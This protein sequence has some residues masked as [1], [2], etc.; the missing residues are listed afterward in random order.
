[1][2]CIYDSICL[3]GFQY[4][5]GRTSVSH[6]RFG[7][8]NGDPCCTTIAPATMYYIKVQKKQK[9]DQ[10]LQA[11]KAL[12]THIRIIIVPFYPKKVS[13]DRNSIHTIWIDLL[14][15]SHVAGYD[16]Y[17]DKLYADR[18]CVHTYPF[19]SYLD[20]LFT[21]VWARIIVHRIDFFSTFKGG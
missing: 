4:S 18:P 9:F 13:S 3:F 14:S 5:F 10:V 21:R 20:R 2:N 15:C 6:T 1:M 16:S 11:V 17:P 8:F 7:F 19:L 12:F